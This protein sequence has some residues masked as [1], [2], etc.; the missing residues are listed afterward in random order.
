[1]RKTL[2]ICVFLFLCLLPA[3]AQFFSKTVIKTRPYQDIIALNPSLGLEKALHSKYSVELELLYLN[4][5]W[6]SSG[7]EGDFGRYYNSD[8]FR[9]LVGSKMYFG[10]SNKRFSD[11]L[12]KAPLGWFINAQ[13]AYSYS[14]TYNIDKKSHLGSFQNKV[15]SKRN[16]LNFNL[17]IGKQFFLVENIVFEF[18]IG[19]TYRSAFTEKLTITEGEDKG[20]VIENYADATISPFISFTI[21]FYIE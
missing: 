8:G 6:N 14:I 16:W 9:V 2:S 1:M 10:K 3:Q 21:G 4:R 18:Y 11:P 17:G 20:S 7:S 13:L 12:Q 19:P 15:D 5:T